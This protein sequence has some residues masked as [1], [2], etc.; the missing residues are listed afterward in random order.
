MQSKQSKLFNEDDDKYSTK[1]RK[2]IL[3]RLIELHN[4]FIQDFNIGDK[5]FD[6]QFSKNRQE[7]C[8]L[9]D[10][11]VCNKTLREDSILIHLLKEIIHASRIFS[12]NET[13]EKYLPEKYTNLDS[14][15]PFYNL[16]KSIYLID[17]S[18]SPIHPF[19][20][21]VY[22]FFEN[23]QKNIIVSAPTSFGKTKL[24]ID[25]LRK[26]Q[27]KSTL[28]IVPTNALINELYKKLHKSLNSHI[29]IKNISDYISIRNS[30]KK[31][32]M[33]I[34]P[35]KAL[36]LFYQYPEDN[37]EFGVMDEV[38]KINKDSKNDSRFEIISNA[39]YQLSIPNRCKYKYLIGPYFDHNNSTFIKSEFKP[40][41]TEIV[42]KK[43]HILTGNKYDT[44][45]RY[46]KDSINRDETTIVYVP[47]KQ[48][49]P[50][51]AN[52]FQLFTNDNKIE[53][54]TKEQ[55]KKLEGLVQYIKKE[56]LEP[57]D[58][59]WYLPKLLENGIAVHHSSIPRE[60]QKRII[61]LFNEK[62]IKVV[63]CT[64]TL[65]EGINLSAKN[66]IFS[67]ITSKYIDDTRI[68]TLKFKNIAGRAGRLGY[69]FHGNVYYFKQDMQELPSD[70]E[71]T[72][73]QLNENSKEKSLDTILQ[74]EEKD[75][76]REDKLKL[77]KFNDNIQLTNVIRKNRF[78]SAEKQKQLARYLHNINK[79]KFKKLSHVGFSS[80]DKDKDAELS[81]TL[82]LC[83]EY[84][85]NDEARR[86]I[87]DDDEKMRAGSYTIRQIAFFYTIYVQSF[88]RNESPIKNIKKIIYGETLDSKI[89]G[90]TYVVDT[91]CNFILP[92]YLKAFY[93]L[94]VFVAQSKGWEN[95][96]EIK[97][98]KEK[99]LI[100][101]TENSPKLLLSKSLELPN[102]IVGEIND[103]FKNCKSLIDIIE[104]YNNVK[105]KIRKKLDDS[106]ML[107]REKMK[108]VEEAF[109]G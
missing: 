33:V 7:F 82:A 43:Y 24:L 105:E 51:Y 49:C 55:K 74:M 92:K 87:V 109:E 41:Q 91:L 28:I 75:L 81:E 39:L 86:R 17:G 107:G 68:T 38:Q 72:I 52:S 4:F 47:T 83:K 103:Y 40:I 46:L 3:N 15:S 35:E 42:S 84:L 11:I 95:E 73:L 61:T 70:N 66:I 23:N 5:D 64:S 2:N 65:I 80:N 69:H 27:F 60:V 56:L 12:D 78:I 14:I 102:G 34:T 76:S 25:I 104:K 90:T 22:N 71:K 57:N 6:H 108:I 31:F 32:I 93:E 67:K 53:Y 77:D 62:I 101:N 54:L 97:E 30:M 85:F 48:K 94:Y 45:N 1:D 13:L 63:F 36:E 16:V 58:N 19:L 89:E 106:T 20:Y 59:D 10:K 18:E 100:E 29:V 79:E 44:I 8:E 37:F 50:V 9:A 99:Y 98:V 26:Y 21:E 96:V 88:E